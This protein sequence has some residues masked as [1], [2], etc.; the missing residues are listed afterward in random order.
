[1]DR[2]RQLAEA[3]R[4][5]ATWDAATLEAKLKEIAIAQGVKPAE[6]VHP[7]RA[8]ASGKTIGPSLYH[9]LEVLGRDR[10]LARFE[11]AMRTF[12]R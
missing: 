6:Y 12:G 8:A 10:V 5:V 7:A 4:H 3:F 2:L 11:R 1:L 9:L